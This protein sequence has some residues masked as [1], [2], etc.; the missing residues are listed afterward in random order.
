MGLGISTPRSN[1]LDF[2]KYDA[3][4]GKVFRVD[5]IHTSNGWDKNSV[6]ITTQFQA[7]MDLR[8]TRV[9]WIDFSMG[10][11]DC[12][13]VKIGEKLPEK[14]SEEHKLGF[15]IN[16]ILDEAI[17]GDDEPDNVRQWLS[18]AKTV[19]GAV[20][21]LHTAFEEAVRADNSLAKKVPVVKLRRVEGIKS[22][23]GTNFAPVFEI[24]DWTDTPVA[25]KTTLE[26]QTGQVPEDDLGDLPF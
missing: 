15:R 3:K 14:P 12:H 24:V 6:D 18:N 10:A 17:C 22:R 19:I 7:A 26:T 4:A 25:F 9:G 1:F 8:N 21:T 13:M 16:L 11:P 2:I 20:D 5:S 23:N